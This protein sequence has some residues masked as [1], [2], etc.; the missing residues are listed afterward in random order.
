MFRHQGL[1][2][3]HAHN[4]KIATIL[5]F[6]AGLVNVVGF[7]SIGRLTTNVT[8]HFAFL[9]NDF[10]NFDFIDGLILFLYLFAFFLGSFVSS[11]IIEITSKKSDK[12]I[13]VVPVAIEVLILLY[14]AFEG[15]NLVSTAPNII[16]LLLLFAMGL[17]NS[18]VTRISNAV[19]RTTHLTG[20]F[21]DLGIEVSQLFFYKEVAQRAKLLSNIQLRF[22]IIT[23]F[24]IGGICGGLLYKQVGYY[25]LFLP[26]GL[27]VLG[28][29]YDQ[30]KLNVLK[31]RRKL[32]T[33]G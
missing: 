26:S 28:L 13:F 24:F 31:L 11:T 20:L 17:Q 4:L 30:L 18:L 32:G 2:R 23:F 9:V 3:T 15:T 1:K 12:N 25:V 7:I 5:S 10:L 21:T 27:L 6:V 16:A 22:S 33:H 14:L 19:V 29:I 8:G